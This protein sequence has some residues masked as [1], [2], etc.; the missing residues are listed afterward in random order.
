MNVDSQF[1]IVEHN[2]LDECLFR[3][4]SR[5]LYVAHCCVRRIKCL[6]CPGDALDHSTDV[7]FKCHFGAKHLDPTVDRGLVFDRVSLLTADVF[8]LL[9][10]IPP[11]P[12]GIRKST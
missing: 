4:A 1:W 8:S 9:C 3:L 6:V 5:N 7:G 11:R 10:R 12:R 2:D